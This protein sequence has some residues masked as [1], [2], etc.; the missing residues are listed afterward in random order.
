MKTKKYN[1]G[2]KMDEESGAEIEVKG[3]DLMMAV[4]QLEA[5]V[6]AGK[7]M[8]SHYKVKACFYSED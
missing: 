7:Q 3:M 1:E 2:G 5:A 4:K 6:K 8:P